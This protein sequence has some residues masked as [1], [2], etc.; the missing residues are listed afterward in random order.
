MSPNLALPAFGALVLAAAAFGVHL[1]DSAIDQINPIHFQGPAVHPRDR[2]AAVPEF[3]AGPQA[4]HFSQHYG[5]EEGQEA[6]TAQCAGCASP[7]A[8][9][10]GD[11]VTTTALE[12]GWERGHR[13][14]VFEPALETAAEPEPEVV[15][16]AVE[17]AEVERYAS[18]AV[19]AAPT[20]YALAEE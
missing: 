6:R 9:Q 4:P 8:E 19:E 20:E 14:A 3:A 5:W 12:A 13:Q 16:Y 11:L 15:R 17:K 7:F 10:G 1:G 18:F 2:G